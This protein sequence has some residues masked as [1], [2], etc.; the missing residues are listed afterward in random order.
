MNVEV[1]LREVQPEDLTIFYEHQL[2]PEAAQMAAFPSRDRAAFDAHWA[3]N[4]L[5]NPDAITRTILY[6]NQ[7]AGSVGSWPRD[8]ARYVGYW[9]G[10]EFWG[11]GI[12]TRAL[13]AFLDI[14]I[15]R[16]LF[17]EVAVHNVGSIRVLE[18]CGFRVEKEA[19]TEEKDIDVREI[20]FVLHRGIL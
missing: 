11:R 18:K 4:V 19:E 17:A 2:D 8:G 1:R 3:I 16:P 9:L 7:V 10:R 6:Q 20:L 14:V 13:M 5:G 12:A 15:E